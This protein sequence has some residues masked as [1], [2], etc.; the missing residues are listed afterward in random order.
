MQK[1]SLLTQVVKDDFKNIEMGDDNNLRALLP[2]LLKKALNEPGQAD[3]SEYKVI[4]GRQILDLSAATLLDAPFD[5]GIQ[6]GDYI[7]LVRSVQAKSSLDLKVIRGASRREWRID[8]Q[9]ALIG[10][11]DED[12]NI[13]PDIDLTPA[14]GPREL[15]V[16]RQLLWVREKDGQWSVELHREARSIV[17][18]DRQRLE[19]GRSRP[20]QDQAEITLGSDLEKPDLQL[21]VRISAE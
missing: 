3:P 9:E 7:F 2:I 15:K 16:S 20:L 17:L 19:K 5:S 6:P 18:V 14:L 12:E 13:F 21:I 11:T 10:R 8:A 4:V 1:V